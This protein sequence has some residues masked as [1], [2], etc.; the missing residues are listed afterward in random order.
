MGK[1]SKTN[2][3]PKGATGLLPRMQPQGA[4]QETNRLLVVVN[5]EPLK[6]IQL[7]NFGWQRGQLVVANIEPP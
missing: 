7:S 2:Q 1:T 3:S 4:E 5:Q 6:L